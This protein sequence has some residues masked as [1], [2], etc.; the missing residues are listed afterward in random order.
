MNR[1]VV[2][3]ALLV[4][5]CGGS[6]QTGG[7]SSAPRPPAA[8][9][10]AGAC[11]ND[12]KT[13][14]QQRTT[15]PPTTIDTS[16]TYQATVKTSKGDFVLKLD[17]KAAPV[18]VNNFVYLSQQGFYDSLTFHRYVPD[19]VIQGGDPQGDGRGGPGYKLPDETNPARWVKASLG[20]ASSPAG[21]NG[22]QFFILLGD[23]PQLAT[24]GVYNHFGM[25][26][27]GME[28]V[29]ALRQGDKIVHIEIATS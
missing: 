28:T 26:T 3:L 5:G 2:L 21:V 1:L 11:Q 16:K 24:S 22:S 20:M 14:M 12:I 17:P 25:V 7:D 27:Q 19:F 10:P 18:T 29:S 9:S 15:P 6:D 4:A 8:A 23:A 13:C